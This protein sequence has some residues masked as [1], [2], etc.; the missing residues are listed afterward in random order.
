MDMPKQQKEQEKNKKKYPWTAKR[1]IALAAILLLVGL[2][3]LLLV[4]ALLSGP[5][6]GKLFRFCLGMTIAVPIFAWIAIYAAGFLTHRHTIASPDILNSNPRSRK[7]IEDA[8][9]EQMEKDA[10]KKK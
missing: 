1:V 4:S 9:A 8:L 7:K 5:G 10:A 6:T 3:V 2:Y